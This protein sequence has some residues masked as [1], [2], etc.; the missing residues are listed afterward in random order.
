MNGYETKHKP[1]QLSDVDA[2]ETSEKSK[3]RIHRFDSNMTRAGVPRDTPLVI[4]FVCLSNVNI[5]T[6]LP[7]R[8]SSTFSVVVVS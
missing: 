3:P 2:E 6:Y 4:I 1:P 7:I 8:L 5:K